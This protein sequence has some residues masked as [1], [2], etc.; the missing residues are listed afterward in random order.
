ISL[1]H[2]RNALAQGELAK[3]DRHIRM[4]LQQDANFL[5]YRQ[6]SLS[7]LVQVLLGHVACLRGELTAAREHFGGIPASPIRRLE[8]LQGSHVESAVG[9]FA[10][11]DAGGAMAQVQEARQLAFEEN[12]PQF[13]ALA[14]AAQVELLGRLGDRAGMEAMAERI[15]LD[16]L[17]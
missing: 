7:Q 4:S 12:L 13:E 6:G 3:A 11:G 17:W 5:N 14:G 8:G 9:E 15:R 16:A 1:Y 10:L 2:A